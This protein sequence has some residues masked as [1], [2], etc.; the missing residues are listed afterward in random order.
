M[1]DLSTLTI[2]LLTTLCVL[3]AA[4][5]IDQRYKLAGFQGAIRRLQEQIHIKDSEL[6]V[7]RRAT[8]TDL[9]EMRQFHPRA[10]KLIAQRKNFI[11][12][13]QS[14]FYFNHVYAIIRSSEAASGTWSLEDEAVYT[15]LT[16]R[17][18]SAPPPDNRGEA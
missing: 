15:R 13:S 16:N 14:E 3:L 2:F 12:V 5:A 11:V 7:L 18:P 4:A 9:Q 10:M 8:P 1:I 6:V 17:M